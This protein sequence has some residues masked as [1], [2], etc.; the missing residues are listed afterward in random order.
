MLPDGV[1][2]K[3]FNVHRYISAKYT[4]EKT[5]NHK[6]GVRNY[7]LVMVMKAR[8]KEKDIEK[9]REQSRNKLGAGERETTT[10]KNNTI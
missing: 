2:E 9:S 3:H 1:P 4:K 10:F 8:G 5:S 7:A 6:K